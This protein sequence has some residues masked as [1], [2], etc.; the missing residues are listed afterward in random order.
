[1]NKVGVGVGIFLLF[2]L[3]F[4]G[5]TGVSLITYSVVLTGIILIMVGIISFSN[6]V[7]PFVL[8]IVACLSYIPVMY[9]SFNTS[10]G[11]DWA[12]LILDAIIIFIIIKLAVGF[13]PNKSLKS[14]TPQSGAP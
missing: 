4:N 5:G 8:S 7:F 6:N 3:L 10:Y 11:V 12:A 14:G 2:A 13:K 1:M 9:L